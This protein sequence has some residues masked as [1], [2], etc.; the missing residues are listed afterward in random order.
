MQ[1]LN[2]TIFG[3]IVVSLDVGI[4]HVFMFFHAIVVAPSTD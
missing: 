3:I 1:A 2:G 4:V